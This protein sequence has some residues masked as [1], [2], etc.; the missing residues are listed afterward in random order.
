VYQ[1]PFR[2][3]GGCQF[4]F[5]CDGSARRPRDPA[6]WAEARDVA[7]AALGGYVEE[8]VGWAT[9]YHS[10][11]VSPSWGPKLVRVGVLGSH[12]FYRMPG[13]VGAVAAFVRGSASLEPELKQMEAALERQEPAAATAETAEVELVR[14]DDVGAF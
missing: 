7:Q 12:I 3:G 5:T 4:T 2:K 9:H 11:Y 6:A 13:N 1:G 10:D 14:E 8:S